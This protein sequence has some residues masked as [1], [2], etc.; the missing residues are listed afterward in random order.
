MIQMLPELLRSHPATRL[1]LIGSGELEHTLRSHAA[2]LSVTERVHLLGDRADVSDLLSAFDI[3]AQ[4]SLTEGLSVAL[5]E[6]ASS[7]LAI[8]ATD[9]G[10]NPRIIRDGVTGLLVPPQDETA[11]RVAILR[12]LNDASLR[13]QLGEGALAWANEHVSI[14]AM[15]LA[16]DQLYHEALT[17]R[18]LKYPAT[19][20]EG[21]RT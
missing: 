19:A 7:G 12:L 17:G 15:R 18:T 8:V 1:V 11:T 5:L 3:F 13:A 4:P 20:G 16:Y 2:E 10:G 6:A 9:V 14:V 21:A